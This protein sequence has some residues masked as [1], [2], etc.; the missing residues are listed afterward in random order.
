M[1]LFSYVD[2]GSGLLVWQIIISALVGAMF[3]LKKF[4]AALGKLGRR[5][6]GK[7]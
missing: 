4:R 5:L 7:R 3:H 2:P 6:I 1:N